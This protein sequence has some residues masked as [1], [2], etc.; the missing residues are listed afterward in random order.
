M[1]SLGEFV[2]GVYNKYSTVKNL[3]FERSIRQVSCTFLVLIKFH[4]LCC[5]FHRQVHILREIG[6]N[7]PHEQGMAVPP[8][9]T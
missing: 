7:V 2:D 4:E 5:E 9:T 1:F 3:G 6:T 8:G